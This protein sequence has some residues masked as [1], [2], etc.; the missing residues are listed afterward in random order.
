MKYF[1]LIMVSTLSFYT[2]IVAGPIYDDFKKTQEEIA[3][4]KNDPALLKIQLDQNILTSLQRSLVATYAYEGVEDI[5]IE[6]IQYE[7]SE[8][9]Q[10]TYYVKFQD[11]VGFFTY[12][13]N[14]E[15]FY[16]LPIREELLTKPGVVIKRKQNIIYTSFS[17]S[18]SIKK[19]K[20]LVNAPAGNNSSTTT[21]N[22]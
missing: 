22:Q 17:E 3:K 16:M 19:N 11:F 13:S 4:S 21:D 12:F 10:F 8:T 18:S 15:I 5:K 14:P 1:L 20:G 7:A 2:F 6:N 9:E